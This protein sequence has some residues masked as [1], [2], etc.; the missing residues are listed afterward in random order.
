MNNK[1][2]GSGGAIAMVVVA[3]GIFI[4]SYFD[5][6]TDGGSVN[7]TNT[8][9]MEI[10]QANTSNQNMIGARRKSHKKTHRKHK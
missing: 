10:Q 4:A 6:K 1:V 2:I 7:N 9:N 5:K 8:T 3:F